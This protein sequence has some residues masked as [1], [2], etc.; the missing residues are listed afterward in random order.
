[1]VVESSW[2]DCSKKLA[3]INPLHG[4][5]EGAMVYSVFSE[6]Q[7]PELRKANLQGQPFRVNRS[8]AKLP[9]NKTFLLV[10]RKP[11]A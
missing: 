3:I 2:G 1:V 4:W 10:W 11:I 7:A 9:Q 5:H 6:L 8:I